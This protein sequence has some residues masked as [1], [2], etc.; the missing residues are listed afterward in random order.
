MIIKDHLKEPFDKIRETG[1][2]SFRNKPKPGDTDGLEKLLKPGLLVAA[3]LRHC[4][5]AHKG[6]YYF[7]VLREL[8]KR[9]KKNKMKKLKRAIRGWL[10]Y[11]KEK[12]ALKLKKDKVKNYMEMT[13][14]KVAND[15]FGGEENPG[16]QD[17]V[18]DYFDEEIGFVD[19]DLKLKDYRESKNHVRF[20]ME[21][22]QFK[23]SKDTEDRPDKMPYFSVVFGPRPIVYSP[24]GGISNS[25]TLSKGRGDIIIQ[26]E[27]GED[28]NYKGQTY[29][30]KRRSKEALENA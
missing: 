26:E 30:P 22:G 27:E 15:V 13:Y 21:R 29:V 14:M 24:E 7:F 9:A 16:I 23:R 2:K 20:F 1:Q 5:K 18:V 11:I 6:F 19:K 3:I 8:I 12:K 4:E 10:L 28:D 17:E 25:Q